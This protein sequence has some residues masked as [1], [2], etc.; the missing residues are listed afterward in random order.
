MAQS[1]RGMF[2]A[3]VNE[4]FTEEQALS[5]VGNVLRTAIEQGMKK[6]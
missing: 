1:V 2:V 5:V 6:Q 3:L 4:G